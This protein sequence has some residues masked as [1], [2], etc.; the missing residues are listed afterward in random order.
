M[1]NGKLRLEVTLEPVADI[2]GNAV[3]SRAREELVRTLGFRGEII[4]ELPTTPL[5]NIRFKVLVSDKWLLPGEEKYPYLQSWIPAKVRTTF[6][7]V[8]IKKA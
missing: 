7:V 1:A 2:P 8:S 5:G 3:V 4:E 6:R